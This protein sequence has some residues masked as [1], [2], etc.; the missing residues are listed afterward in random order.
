M[1]SKTLARLIGSYVMTSSPSLLLFQPSVFPIVVAR[2]SFLFFSNSKKN[3]GVEAVGSRDAHDWTAPTWRR[4]P[5]PPPLLAGCGL[6]DS[7][8]P[9]YEGMLLVRDE[10]LGRTRPFFQTWKSFPVPLSLPSST[11]KVVE[12]CWPESDGNGRT[13]RLP[14]GLAQNKR[15]KRVRF[16]CL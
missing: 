15:S 6:F 8:Q 4:P 16:F 14:F 1:S 7:S 2:F 3:D 12:K 11:A 5:P 10:P 13:S 9:V